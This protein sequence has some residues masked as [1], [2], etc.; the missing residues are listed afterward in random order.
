[1]RI[2]PGAEATVE[3]VV[4]RTDLADSLGS[5]DV[6]VLGTPR[7]AAWCEE[8]AVR[9][10]AAAIGADRTSVGTHLDLHHVAPTTR[11]HRVEARARV[12]SVSGRTVTFDLEARDPAGVIAH[13]T[14]TRAVVER[15]RFLRG[16][17]DR[18]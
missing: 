6:Q 14:H 11:G 4:N 9:A 2:E 10:I 5:G 3:H 1:M 8:A 18:T 12:E 16:A 13:G 7:V 15:E 17:H